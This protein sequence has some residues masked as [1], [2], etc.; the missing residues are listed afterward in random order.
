MPDASTRSPI[1]LTLT[2]IENAA[3]LPA[4]LTST[5]RS[6]DGAP[7]L[8]LPPGYLVPIRSFDVGPVA[9]SAVI[10]AATQQHAAAADDV[11]VLELADGSTLVTSAARLH[12]ALALAHP[13]LLDGDTILL[14][15]LR[16]HSALPSRGLGALIGGVISKVYLL[17]AGATHDSIL[18]AALG[19]LANQAELGV[20]WRGTQALMAAIE[21]RLDQPPG[22]YRWSGAPDKGALLALPPGGLAE[23]DA[24]SAS[25]LLVFVH[26]TGSSTLGSFG[27]LRTDQR[28][29]WS[30]LQRRYGERIFGFEHRTLS[31]SPIDNAIALVRALPRAAHVALVSHSR[32]GLVCDL[33]CLG[34]FD[35]LIDN[36]RYPFPGTGAPDPAESRRVHDELDQ[37]HFAQREQL[38]TLAHLLRER[39]IVVERYVRCASP[40]NGTLLA[41]GNFDVFLS[42]LLT[43]IGA[44]P[45]FFGSPLYSA[46]KR[47]VIEIAK[48][49]TDAHL[50][51]GI[52]AMLPDSPMARLLQEAPVQPG[53]AM[54]LIAGDTEGGNMLSRLGVL[55]TDFLLF[56]K[57]D[58]DLVVNTTS[59]LA[60]IATRSA[61]RVLFE[62]G[63]HVSHFR[64]FSNFETRAALRDWLV[65]DDPPTLPAFRALP[66]PHEYAAA[67]AS[68]SRGADLAAASAAA[69]ARPVVLILPGVM[70]SS[71]VAGGADKVWFD[72]PDLILGGLE[73]I[74]WSQP[75]VEAGELSAALYGQ[76]AEHLALS[77]QVALFPYDWRQPLD[78]LGTRLADFLERLLK[79]TGAPIRLL[80]HSMGGLVVRACIHQRRAL[81]DTLM[82]RPG[83]RLVMLGTPNH[84]AHS[85][86]ENLLGKGDALRKLARL[87]LRHDMQEVLGIIGDFRGALQ[88]LPR[89]GFSDTFQGHDQGGQRFDY[90]RAQT[91]VQLKDKVSDF[92]FGDHCA[93]TPSQATLDAAAWLWRADGAS[94][95]LPA[96]YENSTVYV[97]GLAPNTACGVREEPDGHGGAR[98][99]MVGTAFGDGTVTWDSGRLGGIG[100]YYYAPLKHGD[101]PCSAAHFGALAELLNSGAT[102]L[103]AKTA[104]L[105]RAAVQAAPLSYDAGPPAAEDA[106]TLQRAL[107]GGSPATGMPVGCRRRLAVAVQAM[108]LRF[109]A[110][111]VMVGH[112][113]QDPIAGAEALIDSEL[114]AGDL[115]MRYN[116]GPYAGP[117]GSATVVLRAHGERLTGAVVTG[118]GR[119]EG[120][121]S[122]SDLTECVCTGALRYL[123]QVVDVLGKGEREVRL[124]SLLIGY[125][126]SANL[127]VAASVEA[128]VRGV[129][130]ANARF[131]DST[132]LNIRIARLDLVE[133]YMD[134]A[135][136]AVYALRALSARLA[137]QTG[138]HGATLLINSELVQGEG[139]RQRLFDMHQS[140]YWPRL[141]VTGAERTDAAGTPVAALADRLRYLFVSQRARAETV[142]QQ[143]QPGLAEALVQQ[144]IHDAVW[145][146]DFG[147]MLFQLMIPHDFKGPARQL[148]RLV[149]VLD[150]LTANLPWELMLASE[151]G[152][153][154]AGGDADGDALPLALRAAVVRQLSSSS[155]RPQVRP[156]LARH[157]LVVGN[158]SVR[159]F[160]AA[161]PQLEATPGQPAPRRTADPI[162]LPGAEKE[163][164]VVETLLTA[165]GYVVEPVIG[166]HETAQHVLSALYRQPW[167]VLHVSAH[168]IFELRHAD[169]RKRSGVV[170]SDGLLITAAEIAAMEIVP[171][172]VFLNCC[173]LGQIDTGR[174]GNKLAASVA[175]ELID[176]GVRCVIV[177]GWA[178]RD[179]SAMCFGQAFYEQLL[180]RRL[181]FGDAVFVARKATWEAYPTDIT[182]GAFQAYGDPGWTAEP[183]AEDAAGA[184]TPGP[185]AS[186]EELLDELARTRVSLSHL[187]GAI[188]QSEARRIADN[189]TALIEQRTPPGWQSL[190]QLHSALGAT[191]FELNRLETA[192]AEFIAAIGATDQI[193]VVPIHDIERLANVEILLGE[194]R[195]GRC[196]G[197]SDGGEALIDLA[198]KRLDGLE[199]V[200]SAEPG[201]PANGATITGASPVRSALRASAWKGKAGLQAQHLLARAPAT[202]TDTD[203]EAEAAR[204]HLHA[205][206]GHAIEV[207]RSAEGAP[208]AS[209]F[210]PTLAL[211]RLALESLD[212]SAAPARRD[213][214][215]ALARYCRQHSEREFSHRIGMWEAVTRP[216]AM[217]VEHLILGTL[218]QQGD[219][220]QAALD[221]IE[222]AYAD[223]TS[224]IALKRSEIDAIACDIAL[225][226]RFY[227]VAGDGAAGQA[228]VLTAARLA[229][230]AR[231]LQTGSAGGAT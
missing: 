163:A 219:P 57:E 68:A 22:L 78:V 211:K 145:D 159:G 185:F 222:R 42:G 79:Q 199:A 225:L 173:H 134:T 220:A 119:Y 104:P 25:P 121:L 112:Y 194:G 60:G 67:L 192:R 92:W 202:D 66:G 2:G 149:L 164:R 118:L 81:M 64:Y 124:A 179:A 204:A 215:L 30:L 113:E 107:M 88:L 4:I 127:S 131:Y 21:E 86:V 147:R 8:F 34:D 180:V 205:M 56:D 13:E 165:A 94:T 44:V 71:L 125:N 89:A 10:G 175:R 26:G 223:A 146:P 198:L 51:P 148:D 140:S 98:L 39:R 177:S 63:A 75:E 231:R 97:F 33:L 108:D 99:K 174:S 122:P 229:Q 213:A 189:V 187:R 221:A 105:T 161:F 100:S 141:L 182:W 83:A 93:A 208:G 230:L 116:L 183:R 69:P 214:A 52:E 29:L 6:T 178:V 90:Q 153:R 139:I 20:S 14:E 38:R 191:W 24:P 58:H 217:L 32:G 65:V 17:T 117:R 5:A 169:G 137:G 195:S 53:V 190:P 91:W 47:V 3:S 76:L 85:M 160:A 203:T 48:N 212:A 129:M 120:A 143:R 84:G 168:G 228:H 155:Y 70:G 226:A 200:L 171:E 111:P 176:I 50:V 95:S 72:A 181:P 188:E 96:A 49:R 31:E 201:T 158:P 227:D 209:D 123:L 27:D 59:M 115:S 9:R 102:G 170:L 61:A 135:I 43:L 74:A 150:A 128:L 54:A 28:G 207:Y 157:A 162:A 23:T 172:L 73:K 114:L 184:R 206:L 136:T 36:Y 87:D 210:V 154:P 19:K 82:A 151:A 37:A 197:G 133:L 80:A 1:P 12:G 109:L 218:G 7:D 41:G 16:A 216:E 46:F 167:R 196:V 18:D 152:R 126:S 166:E 142:V 35:E 156:S 106:D 62:R 144:Q 101:L 186:M 110:K 11:I 224:N 103:L 77:H 132:R 15:Q 130:E 193:G 138:R 45:F 40:A 55:L